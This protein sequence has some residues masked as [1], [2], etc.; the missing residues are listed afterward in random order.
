[1][2]LVSQLLIPEKFLARLNLRRELESYGPPLPSGE[3][4]LTCF[5]LAGDLLGARDF[6]DQDTDLPYLLF[7]LS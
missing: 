6:R 1:M 5:L 2:A 7:K 3:G 4:G